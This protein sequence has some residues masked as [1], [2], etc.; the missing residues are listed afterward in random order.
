MKAVRVRQ[1]GSFSGL[2]LGEEPTPVPL[3]RD[4]L[5]RVRAASL[6]FRDLLI[7]QGRYRGPLR[8]MPVPLSDG[9]G[10]VVAVGPHVSRVKVGE[11][12]AANCWSHW[13]GGPMIAE[14]HAASIGMTL[15]GALAEYVSVDEN[16]IV[17]LPDYLTFE[18]AATLPCAAVSAWSALTFGEPLRPGQTVLIQ[19]TGGVALF[20]LQIAR[21]FGARVLAITSS[22]Q[23]V[24]RL[25]ELG[26]DRV[27][28]Y[29]E[30]PQWSDSVLELTNGQGVD[31]VVE[32]GGE[33]T[34]NQSVAC[35]RIGGEIGLVGFVTGFGGGLPPFSIM[36][37]SLILKGI[38]IGPRLSFEALLRAME[39]TKIHPVIDRVFPFADYAAAYAHLERANHVGKVVISVAA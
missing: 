6:N 33:T 20:A 24:Q 29:R 34:I 1:P 31:K 3:G 14:Y 7:A 9:A 28:N 11:R 17:K 13:I 16:A 38:S 37:R 39:A 27:V 2:K 15:D 12:V 22:A 35:T 25:H 18:E 23:K 26:A 30:T 32:I 36:A 21:M 5:I 19:G 4:V 8:D 10:E